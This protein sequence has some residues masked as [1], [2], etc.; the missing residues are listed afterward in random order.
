MIPAAA[1]L[2]PPACRQLINARSQLL[3]LA[4]LANSTELANMASPMP[5]AGPEIYR[6]QQAVGQAQSAVMALDA[7]L[8]PGERQALTIFLNP[9]PEDIAKAHGT[10]LVPE[11]GM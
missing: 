3:R 10:L 2:L 5:Q 4:I 9:K 11:R 6:L 1:T 7:K 8:T